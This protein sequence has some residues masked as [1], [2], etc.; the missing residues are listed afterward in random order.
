VR[1]IDLALL[2]FLGAVWGAVFLFNRIASPEVGAVWAA[3]IR[4][5]LAALV[6]LALFGRGTIAAARGRWLRFA[7]VGATFSAVP[8]TLLSFAALTLPA[9]LGALLN[10]AT[11]MFTALVGAAWLGHAIGPRVVAGL[12]AGTV[13]VLVSVGWSPLDPGPATMIAAAAA[14][15]AALSYAV[16]GTYVRRHLPDVRPVHLATGQLTFGALIVL[17]LAILSGPPGVTSAAGAA[18]LVALALGATAL[19][20]PIFLSVLRTTTATAAS[21]VTFI[22]PVFGMLWAS[23]GLG[24]HIG[25]ELIAGFGL[26]VVSLVLILRIPLPASVTNRAL[27]PWRALRPAPAPAPLP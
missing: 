19:A 27:A 15:G 6:L 3:E 23:I 20:W 5:G 10:A 12:V 22:V 14:L 18:S 26:I 7:V 11:P 24:E 2:V 16:A 1:P 25:P 21:T 17:P 9:S 4:I 13:A 8:F